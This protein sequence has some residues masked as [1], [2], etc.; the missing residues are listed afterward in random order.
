[1][2]YYTATYSFGSTGLKTLILDLGG[3]TPKGL[4]ITMGPRNN[5]TESVQLLSVGMTDGTNTHCIA[6]CPSFSKKWP[7]TSQP[8]YLIAH[9][10]ASGTKVFSATFDSWSADEAVINVDTANANYPLLVEAWS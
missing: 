10:S 9:H 2:A 7:Y 3:A 1:M 6:T 8:N 5:T 4:R